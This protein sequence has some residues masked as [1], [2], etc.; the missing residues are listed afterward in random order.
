MESRLLSAL[1]DARAAL[2]RADAVEAGEAAVARRIRREL[3]EAIARL[4][5]REPNKD[6][7]SIVC[8]DLK[9]P[10]ASI[11]MGAGYLKK[12]VAPGDGASRRVVDAI[13]RSADRM[14]QVVGDFH[15]V[16]KLEMGA[17]TI[18]PRPCD[19]VAALQGA[20]EGF[21]AQARERKVELRLE[22]PGEPVVARCDR[23]RLVQIVSKLVANG[24]KFTPPGGRVT[25]RVGR[26]G[27]RVRV[28][29]EDTGRGI[30]PERLPEI[31][32]RAANARR[33]PRDGPGMGLAIVRGLVELHG[34]EV[35]V[36][37]RMGEGSVFS[38][39]LPA[40]A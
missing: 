33:S 16:A 3:D 30:P 35:S 28:R 40:A 26:E 12:A 39:T 25:V 13:G 15:D 38:F 11:V 21:S 37:S 14:S 19:V 10:L 22:D 23:A 32:D 27:D 31:F 2:S 9:D 24:L 34:G 4:E 8:H 29:V 36:E 18:D 1:R 20:L 7:I 5:G 17:I 6:L